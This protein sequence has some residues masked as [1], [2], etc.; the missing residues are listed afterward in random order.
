MISEIVVSGYILLP[1]SAT[2]LIQT[3]WQYTKNES[4]KK[5]IYYE[6]LI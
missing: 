6:N 1:N 4:N 5:R 3:R 2:I